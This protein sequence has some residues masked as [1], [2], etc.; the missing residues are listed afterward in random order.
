M[1]IDASLLDYYTTYLDCEVRV[2]SQDPINFTHIAVYVDTTNIRVK[3]G[4]TK[5]DFIRIA[6]SKCRVSVRNY[7]ATQQLTNTHPNATAM[8]KLNQENDII[9]K[10]FMD[11]MS[12]TNVVLQKTQQEEYNFM[13]NQFMD[14]MIN[15]ISRIKKIQNFKDLFEIMQE[16]ESEE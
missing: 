15:D 7:N 6:K 13:K 1:L 2:I 12:N 8:Q 11:K 10:Q 4:L 5:E 3:S 9:I 14:E 16:E